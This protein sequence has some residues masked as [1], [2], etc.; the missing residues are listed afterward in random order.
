LPLIKTLLLVL[1]WMVLLIACMNV[2]NLLLVRASVRQSEL[3]VRA[4]LGAGRREIETL[5]PDL[6]IADVR[7]LQTII[8]GNFGF[9]LFRV[10][11]WQASVMGLIGLVLAILGVYGVVSYRTLQ[12]SRE[13]GIRVALGAIPSDIRGLVLRQGA[14]LV[15]GGIVAG[16]LMTTAFAGIL[17]TVLVSV[18]ALDPL[19]C[20]VV[21]TFVAATALLACY[22]PA[23]RALHPDPARVLRRE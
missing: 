15:A 11:V 13:I 12:R 9:V 2:A 20:S 7:P 10:G 18:S 19:T 6:P 21:T 5:A 17:R 1:T 4:A 3:A 23:R 16:L 8:R 14:S 22:I